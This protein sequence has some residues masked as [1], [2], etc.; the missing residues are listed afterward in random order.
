MEAY[1]LFIIKTNWIIRFVSDKTLIDFATHK[2]AQFAQRSS[3]LVKKTG[4]I[5]DTQH[6]LAD[7]Q[8]QCDPMLSM[9]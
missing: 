1:E 3:A 8:L 5:L 2:V 4:C 9:L 7:F 6:E